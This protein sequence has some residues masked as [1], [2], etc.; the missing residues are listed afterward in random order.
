MVGQGSQ[1][2]TLRQGWVRSVGEGD[3]KCVGI[4]ARSLGGWSCLLSFV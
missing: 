3:S 1:A 2:C 4:G